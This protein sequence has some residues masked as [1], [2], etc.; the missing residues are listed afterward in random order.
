MDCLNMQLERG[1]RKSR[2]MI[3]SDADYTHTGAAGRYLNARSPGRDSQDH[4]PTAFGFAPEEFIKHAIRA[5]TFSPSN[6]ISS[7]KHDASL[8]SPFRQL[9]C[10]LSVLPV[11]SPLAYSSIS[12]ESSVATTS[13]QRWPKVAFRRC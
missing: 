12:H 13:S 11:A 6:R 2:P 7:I 8:N 1:A 3:S 5:T 10:K 4:Y 9:R